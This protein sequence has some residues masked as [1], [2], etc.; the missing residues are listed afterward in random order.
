[1]VTVEPD[2]AAEDAFDGDEGGIGCIV[3]RL[4]FLGLVHH[5]DLVDD[6]HDVLAFVPVRVAHDHQEARVTSEDA[7]FLLQ[8]AKAGVLGRFA[9]EAPPGR[10]PPRTGGGRVSAPAVENLGPAP[11]AGVHRKAG[12]AVALAAVAQGHAL[13]P[14]T[15]GCVAGRHGWPSA[16]PFWKTTAKTRR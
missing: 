12:V 11:D 3:A 4:R 7:C 16:T 5:R 14:R 6:A 10:S 15:V 1:M 2:L 8:F 9:V 13:T